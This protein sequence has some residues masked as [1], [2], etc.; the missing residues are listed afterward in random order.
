MNQLFIHWK[1]IRLHFHFF[2]VSSTELFIKC[3]IETIE[4]DEYHYLN[5]NGENRNSIYHSIYK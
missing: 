2:F 4:K 3:D 5:Y 1:I